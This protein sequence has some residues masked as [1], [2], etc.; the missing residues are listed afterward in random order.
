MTWHKATW[1]NPMPT[2]QE[3]RASYHRRQDL[4]RLQE[5]AQPLPVLVSDN[6]AAYQVRAIDP[7]QR[8]L[9]AARYEVVYAYLQGWID[10]R[11][12]AQAAIDL[13]S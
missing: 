9:L 4:K 3:P 12:A 6:G 11:Q 2:K 7:P 1:P 8:V 5:H 10:A 13:S